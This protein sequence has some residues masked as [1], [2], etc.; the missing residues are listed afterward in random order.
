MS[1]STRLRNL[2]ASVRSSTARMRDSPRAFNALTRFEPMKPAAPVTTVYTIFL[3]ELDIDFA[4]LGRHERHAWRDRGKQLIT[5]GARRGRDVV[6][7]QSFA[8]EHDR[9]AD[10]RLR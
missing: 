10:G 6:D 9:A 4:H 2:S 3:L 8:P 7:R 5:D 1:Q